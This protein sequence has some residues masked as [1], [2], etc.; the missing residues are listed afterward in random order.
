MA[1][2]TNMQVLYSREFVQAYQQTQSWLRGTVVTEG[3]V[4]GLS[5]VFN[6][7]GV[8][9][10]AVRRGNNGMIPYGSDGQTTATCTL[11]EYFGQPLRKS[12]FNIMSSA[13]NQREQMQ[14]DGVKSINYSTDQM[15]LTQAATTSNIY[16]SGTAITAALGSM[17]QALA[18]GLWANSV[19]Q[20][21]EVYGLLTP[22]AWARM[23]TIQQFS[24]S[25]WVGNDLPFMKTT[26]WRDWASVK[27][28]MFPNLPG[29]GTATASCFVWHKQSLGHGLNDG[30]FRTM[31]GYN[32]EH[33]YS[34][35]YCRSY[36]G[37]KLLQNNG[38]LKI[39]HD[40]TSA[41]S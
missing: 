37:A 15:I 29:V 31:I 14:K 11:D 34:W 1:D 2:N 38:V 13:P 22:M 39:V 21:G 36:Q 28:S 24:N 41:I 9:K 7:S 17:M 20:D 16:N 18:S 19:P 8:V 25:Q 35:S 10:P 26:Q 5:F 3:T 4:N 12:N 23:M 6:V 27:W 40:D 33:D 30:D 32:E